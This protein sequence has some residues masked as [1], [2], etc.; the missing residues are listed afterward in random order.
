MLAATEVYQKETS[1]IKVDP[2]ILMN[3]AELM[4][5]QGKSIII[6]MTGNS[7]YPFIRGGDK[8]EIYKA[9]VRGLKLSDIILVRHSDG[10]LIRRVYRIDGDD[11]YVIGDAEAA[12]IGPIN[13]NNIIGRVTTVIRNEK[14]IPCLSP[15]VRVLTFAWGVNRLMRPGMIRV[16]RMIHEFG[17]RKEK[18]HFNER[19]PRTY[20]IYPTKVQKSAR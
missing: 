12:T 10:Y 13:K 18:N 20:D 8:V 14:R 2:S 19:A 17:V 3:I 15:G 6:P 5:C 7:M 16:Y 9:D 11:I 1:R 4:F